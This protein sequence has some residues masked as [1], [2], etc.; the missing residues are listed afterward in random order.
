[1]MRFIMLL[2]FAPIPAI[3][4]ALYLNETKF[5]KNI[6]VGVTLPYKARSDADVLEKLSRYKKESIIVCAVLIMSAFACLLAK[7]D[8]NFVQ[9][10]MRWL[11]PATILPNIPYVLCNRDLKKIKK[12]RGWGFEDP[13]KVIV[14]TRTIPE[15]KWISPLWFL[16]ALL[17]S[18]LPF[19]W[20]GGFALIYII[21]A[22][23]IISFWFSY[24]WIYRSKAEK[25]DENPSLTDTLSRIRKRNWGRM[26]IIL[27]YSMAALNVAVS[28]FPADPAMLMVM[29]LV[30]SLAIVA[31]VIGVEMSTRAAQE[32][33]TRESGKGIYLD[34]DDKWI[35]GLFY[36]NPSDYHCFVNDRV[37]TGMTANLARPAGKVLAVLSLVIIFSL[38]FI[39]PVTNT[40]LNKAP[41]L[42]LGETE[43]VSSSGRTEY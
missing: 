43:L 25:V 36:Y 23:C 4:A 9:A 11:L 19:I 33:L 30:I 1:M 31:A 35:W 8:M 24:R 12:S 22:V 29:T 28:L 7:G 20:E 2:C 27:A 26:W 38:P 34:D 21:D 3:M 39:M 42:K 40:V 32:K 41:E 17:I 15:M 14:D 18:L 5:K 10:L 13:D 37:G 16:L 6:V